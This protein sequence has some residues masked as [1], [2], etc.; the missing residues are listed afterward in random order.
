MAPGDLYCIQPHYGKGGFGKIV[1]R[2]KHCQSPIAV[3][4]VVDDLEPCLK[5]SKKSRHHQRVVVMTEC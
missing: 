5:I 1:L 2:G 4:G 3:M